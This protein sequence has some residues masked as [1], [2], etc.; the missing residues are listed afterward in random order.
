MIID[1]PLDLCKR[2]PPH[3]CMNPE[4]HHQPKRPYVC[5]AVT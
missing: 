5:N 3:A 2:Q 4:D 1:I